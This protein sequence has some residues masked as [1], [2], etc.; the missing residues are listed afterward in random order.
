[1]H[2]LEKNITNAFQQK[3][4]EWFAELPRI[5][6][7]LSQQWSL[8]KLE[9]IHNMNWNYVALA[10]KD[11]QFPVV[12][13]IS[14]DK[15]LVADEIRAI[16]YFNG[17]GCI[18]LIDRNI[19]LNALL[20]D[21]AMPGFS[22]KSLYPNEINNVID[23]YSHV[24]K[25]LTSVAQINQEKFQHISTWLTAI[26]T[27]D[28]AIIPAELLNKAIALKNYLLNTAGHEYILH[29][30]LHLENIIKHQS[31]WLAIDPK[32]IRGELEFEVAAFDFISSIEIAQHSQLSVLL[33]QRIAMLATK[34]NLDA[35]RLT[36]WVFVRL[37]LAAAWFI[38]DR[39]DPTSV[40]TLA[41][42]LYCQI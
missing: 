32:G 8:S 7:Q 14:C 17:H 37:I 9:P 41:K 1:M 12:L 20:L 30:D 40:I 16:H 36:S 39:G 26:D 29:G 42:E 22:L 18:Q 31:N 2:T 38:E 4:K 33:Q 13:K 27:A 23:Y 35:N 5:I 19:E 6:E 11:S 10:V 15:K 3:G 34:L 21:Q 25:Q 28:S 24:V